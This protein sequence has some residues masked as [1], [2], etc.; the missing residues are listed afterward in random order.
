MADT[1][2]NLFIILVYMLGLLFVLT[3]G[4]YICDKL[5]E[6]EKKKTVRMRLIRGGQ[7]TERKSIPHAVYDWEKEGLKWTGTD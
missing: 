6:R 3:I 7:Q 4:A 5:D 1:I 2:T